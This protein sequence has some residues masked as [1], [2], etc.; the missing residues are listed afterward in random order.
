ME[1]EPAN[2]TAV[3]LI[4]GDDLDR[5]LEE[6]SP[7]L[8]HVIS[9]ENERLLVWI[10]SSELETQRFQ[11]WHHVHELL[12]KIYILAA[13]IKH[14][15]D[16]VLF[17]VDVVLRRPGR[18]S[19]SEQRHSLGLAIRKLYYKSDG[20]SLQELDG[21]S[22]ITGSTIDSTSTIPIFGSTDP[23]SQFPVVAMGGTFD[24]LHAGHKI[25]LSCAAFL[26]TSKLIIGITSDSLLTKKLYREV[27]E[28]FDERT[29]KTREFLQLIK[30]GLEL[31]LPP[32]TDV[33]GPTGWEP[34]I[35]ALIV[36]KETLSGANAIA[37]HR[38]EKDLPSLQEFV[39]DVIGPDGSNLTEADDSNV[40]KD[41]KISSTHIRKYIVERLLLARDQQGFIPR[42]PRVP[43]V[44]Q[45]NPTGST[46]GT[47]K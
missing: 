14:R 31:D 27:L 16:K 36:S 28:T 19:W 18:S 40:M 25:L 42:G 9:Q 23:S 24:H 38:Q 12:T 17:E 6:L 30:P 3:L 7:L 47:K 1:G 44:S 15:L 46:G 4:T 5:L 39:V 26:T 8:E 21:S 45:P 41:L 22:V 32:L 35:Q 33:Y 43:S 37:K 34:N 10:E 29:K 13:Q 11:D 2:E 20:K